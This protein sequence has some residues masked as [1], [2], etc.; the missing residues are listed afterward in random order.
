MTA[1]HWREQNVNRPVPPALRA[2]AERLLAGTDLDTDTALVVVT[3]PA[4]DHEDSAVLSALRD[5]WDG[6]R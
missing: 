6:A 3:E 1:P 5:G 4:P 2:Y